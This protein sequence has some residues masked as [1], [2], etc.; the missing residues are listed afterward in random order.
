MAALIQA[1]TLSKIYN[2]H[3]AD[4]VRALSEVTFSVEAGEA[5]VLQG[6]SGSGKTSLL[7]LIGCMTRPTSGQL[8]IGEKEVS[9][10]PEPFLARVRRETFGF[11]FQQLNLLRDLSVLD[12]ILLPL[13]PADLKTAEMHSRAERVL[14]QLNLLEK[15]R[16]KV[17]QLSGGE[18]QRV[19]IARALINQP[20]IIIADEPT[21][22]LDSTLSKELLVIL[23]HLKKDGKTIVFA[24]HDPYVYQHRLVDRRFSMHDGVL[25]KA[26]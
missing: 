18:Q 5:V 4:E 20:E 19:A 13:Y 26:E 25:R 9:R 1:H 14:E 11:I 6:P 7:S 2:R 23:E 8:R 17:A 10:L 16:M 3:Q 15:Q 21:A 22:H 12:N 24:T